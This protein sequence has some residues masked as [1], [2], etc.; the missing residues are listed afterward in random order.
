[1][2]DRTSSRRG[3]VALLLA[4]A[5][6]ALG[7][8][9]TPAQALQNPIRNADA[10]G[11]IPGSYI[12]VFRD[13]TA[14]ARTTR[15][16]ADA[17]AGK[18]GGRISHVYT[19][20]LRG[21]AARMDERAAAR[22]AAEPG[23]A[24]VEQDGMARVADRQPNP[25]WGLD[26]I[27]QRALPLDRGYTYPGKAENVTAYVLDTGIF[28]AH[29]DFGGRAADGYDF[30]DDD[31]VAQDCHGHGTHVSGTV[32]SATY[33]VAKGVALVGVR[34]LDCSGNGPWSGVIAGLDWVIANARKPAVANLSLAG[35]KDTSVNEAVRR[36]VAAGIPATIAAGN[37]NGNACDT[38]PASE[39]T[40]ITAGAT[41][42]SDN[43][44]SL[45]NHGSC[46][47]LF[48]PGEG[49][50]STSNS[51]GS[52]TMS[53]T[54]MAAPHIAGAAALYL[55]AYPSASPDQVV[56]AL[57]DN[58]TPDVVRGPGAGSPNKLLYTGFLGG[59][60]TCA[61]GGNSADVAV[62]DAGAAVSSP[63]TVTGCDGAGTSATSVRVDIV[64]TYSA[65]LVIDL[66]GPSGAVYNLKKS[67]GVGS[68]GGVHQTFAVN[69]SAET[70]NGTWNLRVRDVYTYDTGAIDAWTL[71]F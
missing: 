19:A 26:R 66:V 32:G 43:K 57:V 53:G 62:P 54:S 12:V 23:V 27:D 35:S 63:V 52:T 34:V 31:A 18:Y 20:G 39:P 50:T 33:G 64:H 47:D 51:G 48:A 6:A 69:T 49:V 56:R 68:A 24:Y 1:M 28:K 15:D 9:A 37:N 16:R 22:L 40:A 55:S 11:S 61:G 67:G 3:A 21:F 10:P 58:A 30:I 25:T 13:A 45:S 38:S 5:T 71:A 42:S 29:S 60:P 41:N 2:T 65:D 8:G 17:L 44:Y 7:L 36:L 46:L 59:P 4:V 14:V 70:K